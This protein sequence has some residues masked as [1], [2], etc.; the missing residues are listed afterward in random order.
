M[1]RR[2]HADT[3][4]TINTILDVA[5]EQLIT[6]GY[7]KM[8]YTTLSEQS[9]ISR[10]GISH[11]F[12]KKADIPRALQGRLLKMLV[13]KLNLSG[14]EEAF[15]SSWK[16]H[17]ED[18]E[19]MAIWRLAF[20]MTVCEHHTPYLKDF[21]NQVEAVASYK[22]HKDSQRTVEWLIGLTLLSIHRY[23]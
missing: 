17:F 4:I 22:L 2:T 11:H 20:L 18:P 7:E 10:T 12:A 8:S 13:D 21:Q 19:F 6:L 23:E 9:G 3:Q 15:V 14:S 5:T 1:A 16:Q